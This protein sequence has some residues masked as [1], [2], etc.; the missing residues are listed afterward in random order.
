MKKVTN[1]S[2]A[3]I[4]VSGLCVRCAANEKECGCWT[5]G[6][7]DGRLRAWQGLANRSPAILWEH[8]RVGIPESGA[9]GPRPP[10]EFVGATSVGQ[11]GTNPEPGAGKSSSVKVSRA[12]PSRF[13]GKI[14]GG[15]RGER[16]WL[17]VPG[18]DKMTH[19]FEDEEENEDEDEN[20]LFADGNKPL[21]ILE[22]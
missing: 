18:R 3:G 20:D 10:G 21:R 15:P 17:N 14:P 7:K 19:K 6:S 16:I 22:G 11:N 1:S 8:R 13:F 4:Q 9:V 5:A 12:V 2:P